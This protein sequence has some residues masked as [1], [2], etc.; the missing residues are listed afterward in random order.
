MNHSLKPAQ[1]MV[2]ILRS[3]VCGVLGLAALLL[4]ANHASA[5][6]NANANAVYNGWISAFVVQ[7][8]GETY[9][10]NTLT[11]RSYAYM[12]GQA[13]LITGVEDAYDRS[14]SPATLATITNMLNTFFNHNSGS[15][16]SWDSW[17]DDIAWACI[18][19]IRAYQL[20]GNS[21]YLSAATNNFNMVWSRGW[22]NTFGGGIWEN[23]NK[24]SK[25]ALSN[26]PFV[27][28]GCFIYQSTGD[29]SYLTKSEQIYAWVRS[30][31]FDTNNGVVNGS[32]NTNGTSGGRLGT[33]DN[34][35]DSG[36]FINGANALY[37][38]TGNI[39]YYNDALLA[40]NYVT[41]KW[42][43]L[44]ANNNNTWGDEY[45]RA[46]SIFAVQNNLWS[47]YSSWLQANCTA[48]WNNRLTT[49]GYDVT[50]NEWNTPTPSTVSAMEALSAMTA[51]VVTAINPS[52]VLANGTYK[53]INRN[54]GLAVD[55]KGLGTGNG[56]IVQQYA[57]NGGANQQW[58]VTYLGGGLNGG[59]YK[60][61]GVQSGRALEVAGAGTANGTGIDIYD[62]TETANQQWMLTA[63]SGGYYR[64]TPA[65]A[66]STGLDVQHSA[67]TNS[68]LLEIW[69]YSGGNSQQWSFQAP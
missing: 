50:W 25:N 69:G 60:I 48:A 1:R 63:T 2:A 32:I 55:V 42:A 51:Q 36:A 35:Y 37:Q 26:D 59:S 64:L 66:T 49:S 68:A 38:I 9:F 41:N 16:W 54:S 4:P 65:N 12:W 46:L 44:S 11:D 52:G 15:D 62:N 3:M 47:Q 30:H 31:I 29:A 57:Y 43:I 67:T 6:N 13:S 10:V 61:I 8:N 39:Q 56:S 33:S 21:A 27:T 23:M 7:T 19:F 22:D 20:T 17:D 53:I 24:Q 34:V 40:V 5:Q 58:T 18:P 28:I 45:V 14:N